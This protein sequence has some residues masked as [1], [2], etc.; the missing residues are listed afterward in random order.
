LGEEKERKREKVKAHGLRSMG[1]LFCIMRVKKKT[2][3]TSSDVDGERLFES[4]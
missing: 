2:P 1:R 4:H 3:P